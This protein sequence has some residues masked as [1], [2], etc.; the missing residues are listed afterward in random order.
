MVGFSILSSL[1][2][3]TMVAQSSSGLV[4]R[5]ISTCA[6]V[7]SICR[8]DHNTILNSTGYDYTLDGDICSCPT[9]QVCNPV[10]IN[11]DSG[12]QYDM[13]YRVAYG[14]TGGIFVCQG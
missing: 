13:F 9:R 5:Q 14:G 7:G 1:F 2:A 4:R 8:V 10:F 3:I 6:G 11:D 12:T